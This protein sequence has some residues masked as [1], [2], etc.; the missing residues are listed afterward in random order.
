MSEFKNKI[1]LYMAKEIINT[2]R[3]R[4]C[5]GFISCRKN[6]FFPLPPTQAI[7]L[8]KQN[9][10]LIPFGLCN[11]FGRWMIHSLGKREKKKRKKTGSVPFLFYLL[12]RIFL[13]LLIQATK[14]ASNNS[15]LKF[16]WNDHQKE[17][18]VSLKPRAHFSRVLS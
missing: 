14:I 18:V 1:Y 17:R 16:K 3:L 15:L 2:L 5:S 6:N 10:R 11:H 4:K 8:P 13:K 12:K 9:S 7:P